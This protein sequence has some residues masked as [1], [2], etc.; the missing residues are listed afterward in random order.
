MKSITELKTIK[1]RCEQKRNKFEEDHSEYER[2]S[3]NIKS[4]II[5]IRDAEEEAGCNF[6][7]SDVSGDDGYLC[8]GIYAPDA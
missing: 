6:S 4:L 2:L 1:K 8:D 7:W 5:Q 3:A